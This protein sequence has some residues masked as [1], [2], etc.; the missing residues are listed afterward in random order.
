[1]YQVNFIVINPDSLS[2]TLKL[3]K[4]CKRSCTDQARSQKFAMGGAVL[5]VWGRSPKP[6]EANGSLGAEPPAL[7]NF[8]FFCKNNHF[9]AILIKKI[10]LL[11]RGL[12]IGTAN[13]IKLV[14]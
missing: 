11:K 3:C 8:A 9:R 5:G 12:E 14:A 2:A 7:E 1:M 6:P 13:I 4:K 10:M